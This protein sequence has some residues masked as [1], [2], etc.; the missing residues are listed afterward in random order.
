MHCHSL[1]ESLEETLRFVRRST[2]AAARIPGR[3]RAY[4]RICP[5]GLPRFLINAAV[6][7]RY[8]VAGMALCVAVVD[9]AV[10]VAAPGL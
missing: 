8:S 4:A 7:A 10:E 3:S 9:T 5:I 1:K 2:R 6:R